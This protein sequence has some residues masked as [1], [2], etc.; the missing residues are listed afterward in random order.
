MVILQLL[1]KLL[2]EIIIVPDHQIL[3]KMIQFKEKGVF[4]WQ[5]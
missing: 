4:F 2:Y 1:L 5:V 3:K